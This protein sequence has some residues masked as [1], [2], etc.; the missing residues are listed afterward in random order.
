MTWNLD[1]DKPIYTQLVEIIQMQIISGKYKAGDRL[2][3]VRELAAE[4]SVNS[5]TMQKAL[6]ELERYGLII[7]QRTSGRTVTKDTQLIKQTQ[8]QL[9]NEC[10]KN[11][12]RIMN[13]LGYSQDEIILLIKCVTDEENKNGNFTKYED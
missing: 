7:T 5:N 4:A 12:F 13:E 11:F 8:A 3:S 9:A 1:A 6:A 10:I 2:P